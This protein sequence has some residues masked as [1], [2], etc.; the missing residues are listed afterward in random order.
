[1]KVGDFY[2]Q[3]HLPIWIICSESHYSVMFS[4]NI[5]IVRKPSEFQEFDLIYYDE[6]ARQE[7]DIVLTCQLGQ[8]HG[9]NNLNEASEII[10]PIDAV[11]RTKWETAVISW[12]GR[13]KIL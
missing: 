8:Y 5:G 2:K 3:P 1:M 4:P 11:I 13:E 12:N 10:P 9:T 6:L 7:E